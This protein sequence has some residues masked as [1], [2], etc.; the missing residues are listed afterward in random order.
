MLLEFSGC[1]YLSMSATVLCIDCNDSFQRIPSNEYRFT[2]MF[3][4]SRNAWLTLPNA[5]LK[6]KQNYPTVT[7][8]S[9]HRNQDYQNSNVSLTTN[10][11]FDH[12]VTCA[13]RWRRA[14]TNQMRETQCFTYW[15]GNWKKSD[16]HR[17]SF[18]KKNNF[19]KRWLPLH[20]M[21]RNRSRKPIQHVISFWCWGCLDCILAE[22]R[23]PETLKV[24]LQRFWYLKHIKNGFLIPFIM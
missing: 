23:L 10:F 20:F 6:W 9:L 7:K 12:T 3:C 5:R 11:F 17:K 14:C 24:L 22:G 21:L 18:Q 8:S 15:G 4:A 13:Y 19:K 1:F 2:H 16:G